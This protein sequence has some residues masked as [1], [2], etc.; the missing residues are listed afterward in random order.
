MKVLKEDRYRLEVVN[1]TFNKLKQPEPANIN[2]FREQENEK[3]RQYL[4]RVLEV[5]HGIFTSLVF[6]TNGGMGAKCS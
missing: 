5:E 4:Q 6:G 3:K 1:Y 2:D